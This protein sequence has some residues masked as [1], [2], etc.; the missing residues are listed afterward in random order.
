M[1]IQAVSND[2]IVQSFDYWHL[3]LRKNDL[4]QAE[5]LHNEIIETIKHNQDPKT[6][7][8]Y[9]LLNSR[10]LILKKDFPAAHAT[11]QQLEQNNG[12]RNDLMGFYLHY[13]SGILFTYEGE[14]EHA[15]TRFLKAYS[16]L[17][18]VSEETVRADFFYKASVLYY[19]IRQPLVALNYANDALKVFCNAQGYEVVIADCENILGLCSISLKQ[20]A[21][22]EEHFLCALDLAKKH[23]HQRLS[24]LT[25]YNL[26]Y[27]YAEQNLS[28]LAIRYLLEVHETEEPYYKTIFL[29]A[30]EYY[31]I[32][33][34]INA[35]SFIHKGIQS[36][37]E[38]YKHHFQIVKAFHSQIEN[39]ELES[40]VTEGIRYFEN[41]EL[42]GFIEDYSG[43]LAQYFHTLEDHAR[44]SHYFDQA[45]QA[46]QTLQKKEALK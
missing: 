38:E 35:E 12:D 41:H 46:K 33:D 20:Y 27:L 25:K 45:Y 17:S 15:E 22:A 31:K 43:E 18:N 4:E 32:N 40:I 10:H 16:L 36:T 42:W 3:S 1:N 23:N 13:F 8:H 6:V 44:A 28:D 37:N 30:R 5:S 19:H 21:K 39:N 29:L 24:H 7:L 26:G 9:Q 14:Y 34:H 11:L 2:S